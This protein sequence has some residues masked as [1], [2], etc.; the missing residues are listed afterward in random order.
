[1]VDLLC[2]TGELALSA[3]WAKFDLRI[4]VAHLVSRQSGCVLEQAGDQWLRLGRLDISRALRFRLAVKSIPTV[5]F[6]LFC[7][8]KGAAFATV[9][10]IRKL[11]SRV[12]STTLYS[13][14]GPT[15]PLM[16]FHEC[17]FDILFSCSRAIRVECLILAIA[18]ATLF[19][20]LHR[21]AKR[22]EVCSLLIKT[23]KISQ[24]ALIIFSF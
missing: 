11:S 7:Y 19:Q 18:D 23:R 21:L 16:V 2:L 6:K 12:G 8:I 14:D 9:G 4:L 24:T 10:A 17:S 3:S 20:H 22:L 1:V 13:N 5:R 15:I